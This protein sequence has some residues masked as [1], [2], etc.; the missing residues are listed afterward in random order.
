MCCCPLTG[1]LLPRLSGSRRQFQ[2]KSC[3]SHVVSC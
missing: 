3:V 1:S 2:K